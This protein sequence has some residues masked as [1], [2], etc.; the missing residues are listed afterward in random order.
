MSFSSTA[1]EVKVK[2]GMR[3]V[4][5]LGGDG[6]HVEAANTPDASVPLISTPRRGD[7]STR[8]A[9]LPPRNAGEPLLRN[10][11]VNKPTTDVFTDIGESVLP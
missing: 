4:Q 3:S 2:G 1:A 7:I 9:L 10:T 8:S 5:P 6:Q 11:F